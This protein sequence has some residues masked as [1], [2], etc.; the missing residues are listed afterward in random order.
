MT[1]MPKNAPKDETTITPPA[2]CKKRAKRARAK[3]GAAVVLSPEVL[4]MAGQTVQMPVTVAALLVRA[5]QEA[6]IQ[7][8]ERHWLHGMSEGFPVA[9][10]DC[11]RT[12]QAQCSPTLRAI[13]EDG[14]AR[15]WQAMRVE[16][17]PRG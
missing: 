12:F 6:W 7:D 4:Q 8:P 10:Y 11:Y 14:F 16:T 9:L 13:I 2:P 1:D 3:P 17:C 15:M 5:S